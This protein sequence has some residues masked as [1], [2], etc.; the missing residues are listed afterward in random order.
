MKMPVDH[1]M[2]NT[3][4]CPWEKTGYHL[5]RRY[6]QESIDRAMVIHLQVDAINTRLRARQIPPPQGRPDQVL[7]IEDVQ[8]NVWLTS[9][10]IDQGDLEDLV[11]VT[12]LSLFEHES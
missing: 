3:A 7:Y 4:D 12:V 1:L 5:S 2:L 11:W 9:P 8:V 6:L 10:R